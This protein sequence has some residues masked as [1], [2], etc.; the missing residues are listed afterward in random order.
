MEPLRPPQTLPKGFL[1]RG[2]KMYPEEAPRSPGM[3]QSSSNLEADRACAS[4]GA[5][6]KIQWSGMGRGKVIIADDII[7]EPPTSSPA[8]AGAWGQGRPKF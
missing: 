2:A 3:V 5:T 4:V 8:P 1:G 7:F 6:Q